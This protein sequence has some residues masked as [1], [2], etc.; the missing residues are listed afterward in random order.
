MA[1]QFNVCDSC[2]F[3]SSPDK[4]VKICTNTA[5]NSADCP[6]KKEFASMEIVELI[7]KLNYYAGFL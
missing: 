1:K 5:V 3:F 2:V 6:H 4:G 7:A